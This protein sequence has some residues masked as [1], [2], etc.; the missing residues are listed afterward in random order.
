MGKP[1]ILMM[2]GGADKG[3]REA[4][5]PPVSTLKDTLWLTVS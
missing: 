5:D 3:P 1:K 4:F 2:S